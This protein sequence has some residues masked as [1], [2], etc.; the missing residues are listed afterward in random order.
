MKRVLL[1]SLALLLTLTL[2]PIAAKGKPF[3][4]V[5][6]AIVVFY[7]PD[8]KE[9]TLTLTFDTRG[10]TTRLYP[11]GDQTV[12]LE[13]LFG[14]SFEDLKEETDYPNCDDSVGIIINKK[15]QATT[16]VYKFYRYGTGEY[17]GKFKYQLEV[18]GEWSGTNLPYGTIKCVDDEATIFEMIY[19]RMSNKPGK[20]A[21]S[22]IKAKVVWSGPLEFTITIT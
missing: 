12:K 5:E 15:T 20:G 17:K 8:V 21:I 18:S 9:N 10:S 11:T 16:I 7:G 14:L 1:L 13:F 22:P 2:L 3:P 19:P 4:K 6:E